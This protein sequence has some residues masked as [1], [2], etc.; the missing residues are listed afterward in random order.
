MHLHKVA[1]H[2]QLTVAD[3]IVEILRARL[4]PAPLAADAEIADEPLYA[5][6]VEEALENVGHAARRHLE[7]RLELLKRD[8]PIAF[9]VDL[10]K[11]RFRLLHGDGFAS[12]GECRSQLFDINEAVTRR[13]EL[14]K[15][16]G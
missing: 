5:E 1:R 11:D 2:D 10:V 3:D 12:F 8:L 13:I 7:H 9:R 15:D 16:R 6:E 4:R 14:V